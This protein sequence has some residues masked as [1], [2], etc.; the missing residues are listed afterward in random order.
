MRG[1]VRRAAALATLL[2]MSLLPAGAAQAATQHVVLLP[3]TGIVD[4]VMASYVHDGI[5]SAASSGAAAV[6]L[7]IDTPGGSLDSTR[8]ITQDILGSS[9]PVITWVAPQ[10]P[11][12]RVPAPSSPLPG[13]WPSWRPARTSALRPPWAKT[14]R[15]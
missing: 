14:A 12:R 11:G 8:S 2:G 1:T 4:Q 15:T 5:A 9:I 10:A 7:E 3:L 13:R 6:V